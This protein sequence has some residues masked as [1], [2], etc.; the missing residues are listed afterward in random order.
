[1]V[2]KSFLS[3]VTAIAVMTTGAMA[4]DVKEDGTIYDRI[5]NINA[6]YIGGVQSANVLTRSASQKGDAIVFPA[7]RQSL[8]SSDEAEKGWA[9]E[10][11][12]RNNSANAVLAKVTFHSAVDSQELFDF[13]IYLS[14]HDA[15]RFTIENGTIKTTDGSIPNFKLTNTDASNPSLPD[16]IAAD[17]QVLMNQ[18]G[19][20]YDIK[21]GFN[22]EKGYF[23]VIAMAEAD[24]AYHKRHQTLYRDYRRLLDDCRPE[25]RESYSDN[26]NGISNGVIVFNAQVAFGQNVIQ[27][28]IAAPNVAIDCDIPET[29]IE[30]ADFTDPGAEVLFGTVRLY[31]NLN[32][33]RD[34]IIPATAI[35]NVTDANMLIYTE[36]ELSN[37]NDRTIIDHDADPLTMSIYDEAMV[38]ADAATFLT[39][40]F[41]YTYEN[42]SLTVGSIETKVQNTVLST[43][44]GKRTL[45]QLGNDDLY[46]NTTGFNQANGEGSFKILDIDKNL[47]DEAERSCSTGSG[48]IGVSPDGSK[49]CV[50]EETYTDELVSMNNLQDLLISSE[51]YF[52]E[53]TTKG[54]AKVAFSGVVAGQG[55]PSI[56]TQMIGTGIDGEAQVNWVYS[57][58]DRPVVVAVP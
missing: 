1:M 32:D 21:E 55:L 56:T 53:E 27:Q 15:F 46:W 33:K 20:E 2:Q 17:N 48:Y 34:L 42:T 35:S 51:T 47:W 6:A 4:F 38:R 58:V 40:H 45:I 49:V 3:T 10:A 9:T 37:I 54:F 13:N 19:T 12:I 39:T 18:D 16:T 43:Q 24:K 28:T 29:K 36:A 31:N 44:I 52:Q 30:G 22:Q 7:F 23:T 41:D 50:A 25:W 5:A 11:V 26:A 8:E 14:G 57:P